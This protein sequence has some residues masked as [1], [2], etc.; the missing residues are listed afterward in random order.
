MSWWPLSPNLATSKR[1]RGRP[2]RRRARRLADSVNEYCERTGK[3]RSTAFREMERGDLRFTQ[4]APGYPRRIPH[5]EYRRQGFDMPTDDG[6]EKVM[7]A[8]KLA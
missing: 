2:P 7:P 3:S 1:K 6:N 5:S 4:V 8:E